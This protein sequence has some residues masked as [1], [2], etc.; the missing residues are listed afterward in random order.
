[1]KNNNV[2]IVVYE[3]SNK[4]YN[5][6]IYNKIYYDY[7]IRNKNYYILTI[8]YKDIYKFEKYNYKVLRYY[9]IKGIKN[10]IDYNKLQLFGLLFSL[11]ILYLLSNT[12]FNIEINTDNKDLESKIIFS[13]NN[14]NIKKYKHKKTFE[15]IQKIKE[16][17]LEEN[18]DII[19]W[20]EITEDGCNY[21]VEVT[22][23]IIGHS[24]SI[25]NIPTNIVA[26]SDGLIKHVD[27]ISGVKLKD[28]ND[29]V[30]KGDI[31]ITGNIYKGET[32]INQVPSIGKIYAEVWYTV[33]T[34]VPF[35]YID[36]VETGKIIKR[37]YIKVFSKEF[38]II[39]K[40]NT[41][42]SMNIK[43]L[44]ID[45]PY[46]PFDVYKEIKKEY[47]Y[48]TFIKTEN[49]AYEEAL[50]RS[51]TNIKNTLSSDEYI[52]YKNTLKKQV[53]SS[54]IEVEIFY[55]VYKNVTSISPIEE[56]INDQ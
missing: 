41:N 42:N 15:E 20:I 13:L 54:K 4:F 35:K 25:N 33:K 17:I 19:E 53:F 38:T 22:E 43:E 40:Y 14:N 16:K 32:L 39:G 48:K 49:Q 26:S 37:Y 31:I 1:M 24:E 5:F 55:K 21:I 50:L 3:Q 11:V 12:I 7:L 8:D 30:K 10:F 56:V 29:Y 23:K 44:I 52:I 9:G 47:K 6:L 45:K 51:D 18:K 2:K 27:L 34:V 28:I 36:Y 46:L